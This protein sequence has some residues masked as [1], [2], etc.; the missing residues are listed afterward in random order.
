LILIIVFGLYFGTRALLGGVEYP[1]LAVSS[2]SMFPTLNIGDLIIVQKID[3]AQIYADPINGDILVYKREEDLIVHR[4]ISATYKG[5]GVWQITTRGDRYP[6]G[7]GETWPST[8]L[9]GKVIARIPAI[10]N[11]PL[12]LH[13]EKN[14]YIL[15]IALIIIFIILML[16]FSSK[17]E[18]KLSKKEEKTTNEQKHFSKI[19][20]KLIFY[21]IL[22]VILVGLIIFSLW[23][24]LPFW[25]PGAG[26]RKPPEGRLVTVYGMFPDVDFH[27]N[28]QFVGEAYLSLG[29]LTYQINY[30]V[31]GGI[32]QGLP[33]FSWFQ[34]FLII[35]IIYNLLKLYNFLKWKEKKRS[36]SEVNV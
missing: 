20:R 26:T 24:S 4:A 16:P 13:S 30:E 7:P 31:S 5:S 9:V 8:Q 6:T 21:I 14:V 22:N 17:S 27:E 35:L 12:F 33:T 1:L 32:R 19:S 15:F 18:E 11:I 2:E 36:G 23:G 25:Q 3:P 34:F 10:G 28:F 29:F